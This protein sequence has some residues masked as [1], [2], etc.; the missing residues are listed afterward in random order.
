MCEWGCVHACVC[1]EC[2]CV[3]VGVRACVC[4]ECACVFGVCVHVCVV[5]VRV[6]GVCACMCVC[7]E[8]ACVGGVCV[9]V[10]VW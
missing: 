4:G 9:H 10:C 7:G 5:S 6:W 3:C 8:C 2:A 1:G